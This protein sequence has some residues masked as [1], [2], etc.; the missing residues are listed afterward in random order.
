MENSKANSKATNVDNAPKATTQKP[1]AAVKSKKV[2][3][4]S[5]TVNRKDK[6]VN[7][8]GIE[9]P[10]I[11][12]WGSSDGDGSPAPP[13]KDSKGKVSARLLNYAILTLFL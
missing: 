11:L 3:R 8:T 6:V 5:Q 9:F 13:V 12:E 7:S 4:K 2:T 1:K 10:A